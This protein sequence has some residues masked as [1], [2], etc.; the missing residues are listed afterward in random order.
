MPFDSVIV[1]SIPFPKDYYSYDRIGF[2]YR[3]DPRKKISG[4]LGAD[5]GTFYDGNRLSINTQANIRFQPWGN[6]G[7]RYDFNDV[8]LPSN[9]ESDQ[10]HLFG[11]TSEISFSNK[12]FWTTFLQYNTQIDNINFNS[13]FQWR[14]LPMSDFFVVYT[15]NYFPENLTIKNRGLI[16]KLTYWFKS[17]LQ[18]GK[19]FIF[20]H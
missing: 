1:G 19:G 8:N 15:E 11:L 14:F 20:K 18:L 12:M 13:R 3:L 2:W 10:L 7:L 9:L 17:L 5:Y 16:L 4:S 6:F